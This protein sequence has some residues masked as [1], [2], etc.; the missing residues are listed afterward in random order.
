[1]LIFTDKY[2]ETI[3]RNSLEGHLWSILSNVVVWEP[4]FF[5]VP[6][7]NCFQYLAQARRP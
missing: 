2:R 5:P 3:G 4:W 7:Q 1:M 6:G